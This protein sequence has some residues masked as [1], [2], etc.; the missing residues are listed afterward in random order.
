MMVVIASARKLESIKLTPTQTTPSAPNKKAAVNKCLF[1]V[2]FVVEC[3]NESYRWLQAKLH[4]SQQQRLHVIAK[5]CQPGSRLRPTGR[6]VC[7]LSI[8]KHLLMCVE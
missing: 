1:I 8:S 5:A 3:F 7:L 4:F 6:V 2:V